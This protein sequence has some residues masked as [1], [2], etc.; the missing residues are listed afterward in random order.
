MRDLALHTT[1]EKPMDLT[2]AQAAAIVAL[3]ERGELRPSRSTVDGGVANRTQGFLLA[4]GF[5][6][7]N[8]EGV[9]VPLAAAK[10]LAAKLAKAAA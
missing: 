6:K 8:A 4:N 2:T 10:K 7:R 1:K 9:L 3:V 5:A